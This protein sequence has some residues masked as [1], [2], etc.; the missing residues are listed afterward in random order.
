MTSVSKKYLQIAFM[1][2]ASIKK[3]IQIG[4]ITFCPTRSG[5]ISILYKYVKDKGTRDHIY[6]IFKQY[7]NFGRQRIQNIAL[8]INNPL[9]FRDLAENEKQNIATAKHILSFLCIDR[10]NDRNWCTSDNFEVIFQNFQLGNDSMAESGGAIYRVL[11]GGWTIQE[12]FFNRPGW[13]NLSQSLGYDIQLL[14]AFNLCLKKQDIECQRIL[15]SV[16]WYYDA[17]KNSHDVSYFSRILLLA[18]AFETLL[19]L[20]SPGTRKDFCYKIH[21]LLGDPEEQ[22]LPANITIGQK[23]HVENQTEKQQWAS[24]FYQLRSDIVHGNYVDT[25]RLI[26]KNKAHFFIAERFYRECVKKIL[27]DK[28]LYEKYSKGLG[29]FITVLATTPAELDE[30]LLN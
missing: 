2:F 24:E 28:K 30:F 12:L 29:E 7:S 23:T 17:Y 13:V 8:V 15:R 22:T 5:K 20:K 27:T 19:D 4:N 26:Y 11:S 16:E 10:N 14:T 3:E 18:M 21:S 25:D 6:K 9:D 1:P